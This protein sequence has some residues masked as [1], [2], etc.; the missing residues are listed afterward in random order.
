METIGF[1]LKCPKCDSTRLNR[2]GVIRKGK[3]RK[4]LYY[5]HSCG[6]RTVR[7]IPIYAMMDESSVSTNI[8]VFSPVVSVQRKP[9]GVGKHRDM[10]FPHQPRVLTPYSGALDDEPIQSHTPHVETKVLGMGQHPQSSFW[11]LI[12]FSI[13]KIYNWIV[14]RIR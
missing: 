5:C 1:T 6:S 13:R 9:V 8:E 7:P 10:L 2:Q 11:H 4:Q 12:A 3:N 14:G